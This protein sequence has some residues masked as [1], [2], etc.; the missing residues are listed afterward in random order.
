M[1]EFNII[2]LLFLFFWKALGKW[3]RGDLLHILELNDVHGAGGD[4]I[5][6]LLRILEL[7][8]VH[9]GGGDGIAELLHSG[10]SGGQGTPKTQLPVK[11]GLVLGANPELASQPEDTEIR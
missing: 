8:D 11:S 7:N 4:G 9:G 6:E 2:R 10:F 1:R 5:A 3:H